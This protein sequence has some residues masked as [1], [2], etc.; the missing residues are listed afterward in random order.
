MAGEPCDLHPWFLF[1]QY[2]ENN[3]SLL[4]QVVSKSPQGASSPVRMPVMEAH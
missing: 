2:L 3:E 1:S 4:C